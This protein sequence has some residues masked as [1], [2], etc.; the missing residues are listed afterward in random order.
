[1][2]LFR[3]RKMNETDFGQRRGAMRAVRECALPFAVGAQVHE[4]GILGTHEVQLATR[5]TP[6]Q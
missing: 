4:N 3:G 6:A 1:M 2:N 5:V